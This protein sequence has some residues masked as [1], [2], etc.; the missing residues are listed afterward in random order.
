MY[1]WVANFGRGSVMPHLNVTFE[2]S[3]EIYEGASLADL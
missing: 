2:K 1:E 3:P